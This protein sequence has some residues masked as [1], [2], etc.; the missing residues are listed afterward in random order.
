VPGPMLRLMRR[1]PV[2]LRVRNRVLSE[3]VG[4]VAARGYAGS[5]ERIGSRYGGWIV[6]TQVIFPGS[7]CYLAGLGEDASLDLA[8]AGR[9]CDVVVVDP[10][11]RAIRYAQVAF[12]GVANVRFLPVGLWSSSRIMRFHAPADPA[13]VSHSAVNLQGTTESFEAPCRTLAHIAAEL[14][15]RKIDLL[16]LDIEGAE[17][18]VLDGLISDGLRPSAI[19]VEFDQPVS[20]WRI[21]RQL[22]NLARA[23]YD[24]VAHEHWNFTLVF[25]EP[26]QR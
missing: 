5:L 2:L 12:H 24:A 6:P 25:R 11:P 4:T 7:V 23:G 9:G 14:D 18:E 1:L 13:H 3:L 17:F 8:L 26:S 16:K 20:V 19:C 10:T 15:H 22:R 21:I